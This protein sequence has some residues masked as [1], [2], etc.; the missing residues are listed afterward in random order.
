ML[1]RISRSTAAAYIVAAALAPRED[2]EA[3]AGRLRAAS[4]TATPNARLVALADAELGRNG[5]MIRAIERIGRGEDAFEGTPFFL[6][7]AE[8]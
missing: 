7:L 2:E 3:L 4:A 6:P 8:S 1:E 5:R